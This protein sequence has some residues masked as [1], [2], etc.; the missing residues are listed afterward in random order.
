MDQT[1]QLKDRLS[2]WQENNLNVCELIMDKQNVFYPYNTIYSNTNIE[3]L[4]IHTSGWMKL[5]S[6]TQRERYNIL[7]TFSSSFFVEK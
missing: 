1:L 2:H 6:I 7:I 3:K 5:K 4:L